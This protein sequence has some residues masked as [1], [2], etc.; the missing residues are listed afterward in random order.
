MENRAHSG[1]RLASL[2]NDVNTAKGVCGNAMTNLF[3][4]L[5]PIIFLTLTLM[6]MEWRVGLFTLFAGLIA[7]CGQSLFAK[8]LARLAKKRLEKIAD[9]TKTLGDI[10]AGGVI[11]RTFSF[12]GP[13]MKWFMGDNEILK[14]LSYKEADINAA[15][16]LLS[17]L[18]NTL[19]SAGVFV[20]GAL[21]I[22]NPDNGMTLGLLMAAF[23][24][25]TSIAHAIS[26]IGAC[27]AGLQ[28]PLEAGYRV[29]NLLDG[30][31]TFIPLQEE[32]AIE[33]ASKGGAI[34]INN[35]NFTYMDDDKN[36]L[37]DINVEIPENQF[38]AFIGESGSGKSTLL[39]IITGL[40]TRS[41]IDIT[42]G[43]EKM[44][45]ENIGSWRKYFAYV[46]QNYVLFNL[47][48]GENIGLGKPMGCTQGEIESAAK[49]AGA[50][51]FIMNLPEKYDTIVGE[52]GDFL[53][54]GQKQR[55]AIAR[56]LMRRSPILVFDEATGAL[57]KDS[58]NEV[59]AV[60]EG[61]RNNHTVLM[62]THNPRAINPD[63]VIKMESGRIIDH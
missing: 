24:L 51:D 61:L 62:A 35:L 54:G 55:I 10:F 38:A 48:I 25:S 30:D 37:T 15:Q 18:S 63:I 31:N 50:H 23:P 45:I 9:I 41:D 3:F 52:S 49:E 17:G 56:A 40:Y 28:A 26:N 27:W 19:V 46:D 13:I 21:L 16:K 4:S 47:T 5:T 42:I 12:Q 8:P 39:K 34:K 43:D 60:I 36:T 11:A 59:L 44:D 58:E 2:N 33:T 7:L 6:V 53:S 1:E 22:T 20:L 32:M 57:D 29:Y 14:A